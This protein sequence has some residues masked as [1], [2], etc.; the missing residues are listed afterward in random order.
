MRNSRPFLIL[1]VLDGFGCRKEKQWNAIAEAETP[2]FDRLFRDC[3]WT[4]LDASGLAVGLPVGQMGNSEVGHLNMGAGRIVDQ[5]IVRISKAMDRHELEKNPVL[6][7]AVK[8]SERIHL[9]GLLSDG[10]VHSLQEHLYGLITAAIRL[11]AKD[12]YV[13]A[14]LDGRDTPP[15]SA[16]KYLR[17]LLDFLKDKPQAHLSTIIGRYYTMDRDKRWER[18]QRGYDLMTLAVGSQT[19]DPIETLR[20]FYEQNVTDE[21]MEP[22]AVLDASGGHRGKVEDGDALLFFNFRADRMRQIVTAFKDEDFSAFK[23]TVHPKVKIA[24]MNRYHED[25]HLPVLFPPQQVKNNLGEVWSSA[26]LKQLRIAET[27]KYA[28]VTFFFNGG[29][30]TVFPGEERVLIPSPKVATY[31]LKPEMSVPE[32]SDRVVQG[33]AARKYDVIVLNIANPDM[34]GHTGVMKAAVE[35]VHD[36]DVAVAKILDAVAK[37]DGVAVITADHGNCELMFDPATNQPHTAHTTNPVPLIL[38]D[39]KKRFGSLRSGGALENVAPTILNILGIEQPKEM[40]A[41]SLLV[42]DPV[43]VPS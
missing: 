22:I 6:I 30:D 36:T 33:I 31:D 34:V 2:R 13:H 43:T 32:L 23:R 1:I 28:H 41:E 15:K 7:D 27:E 16:E 19:K 38:V 8:K 29:S 17:A 40:T 5:D 9:A 11:G 37:V 10:G 21:F 18:V 25:F 39:P 35:A 12:V 26:G 14:I 4:T 3:P 20:R 24:T 42:P